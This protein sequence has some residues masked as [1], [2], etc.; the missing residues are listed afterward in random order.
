[1]RAWS[2]RSSS[3]G[4]IAPVDSSQATDSCNS[5]VTETSQ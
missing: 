4:A 3:L 2:E 1:M 5:S